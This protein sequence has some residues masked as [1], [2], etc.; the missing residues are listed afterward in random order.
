M[1]IKT[2][3]QT[4]TVVFISVIALAA[5]GSSNNKSNPTGTTTGATTGTPGGTTAGGTTGAGGITT[6]PANP[7]GFSVL[8]TNSPVVANVGGKQIPLPYV[9]FAAQ[10]A[11]KDPNKIYGIEFSDYDPCTQG[12]EF[13][14]ATWPTAT[15]NQL[16]FYFPSAPTAQTY[17]VGAAAGDIIAAN[18]ALGVGFTSS[19]NGTTF[20]CKA[21]QWLALA[22]GNVTLTASDGNTVTGTISVTFNDGSTVTGPFQSGTCSATATGGV[23]DPNGQACTSEH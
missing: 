15:Y 4:S 19:P 2:A 1:N 14:W 16:G 13:G 18:G 6:N 20:E 9:I 23:Q 3:F 22:G 8:S 12:T 17:N 10:P 11:A 5:C 7:N 21:S